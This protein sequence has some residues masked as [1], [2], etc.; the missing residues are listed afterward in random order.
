[1]HVFVHAHTQVLFA[2]GLVIVMEFILKNETVLGKTHTRELRPSTTK[3]SAQAEAAEHRGKNTL[4]FC[5]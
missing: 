4:D 2:F 1:M 3:G 5:Q